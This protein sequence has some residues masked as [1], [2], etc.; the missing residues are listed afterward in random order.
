[1][2]EYAS[3]TPARTLTGSFFRAVLAT[4]SL[5][6][7]DAQAH[8]ERARRILSGELSALVSAAGAA[9]D[10]ADVAAEL[11]ARALAAS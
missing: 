9:K 8:V 1:M 11:E 10:R 5:A 4:H 2:R 3:S 6:F 7:A